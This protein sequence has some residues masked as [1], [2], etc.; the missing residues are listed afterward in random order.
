[1]GDVLRV[2]VV[3]VG[4]MGASHARVLSTMKGVELAGVVDHDLSRA[5]AVAAHYGC[6]AVRSLEEL[7]DR[8]DAATIAVPSSL[9][10]EVASRLLADGVHCMIEKPFVTTEEDG[11]R[12]LIAA[13]R[14]GARVLVGH[15]ERFNPAVSQLHEILQDGHAVLALDARRMSAVSGRITDVDVV[16]DL[17]VHDLDIVLD[18]VGRAPDDLV[19]RAVRGSAGGVDHVTVLLTFEGGAMASLTASRIAQN[20]IRQLQVMSDKRFFAIDYPNQ[21]LLIFRQGRIEG[22]CAGDSSRYVLDVGTER[23]FVRRVEPLFAEMQHFVQVATGREEPLVSGQDALAVMRV[24]WAIHAALQH[25][26]DGDA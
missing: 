6:A 1:M 12:V 24:V 14:G 9:H 25:D 4:Q 18:L 2:G 16:T 26:E 7:I 13:E 8:C 21:E 5:E 10:A 20:Q 19:A 17:M 15:I 22:L 11:A 3:G 23:V